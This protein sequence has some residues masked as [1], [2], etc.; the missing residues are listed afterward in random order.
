MKNR[1]E[2]K[3]LPQVA[4]RVTEEEMN[5]LN[6]VKKELVRKSYSD[7]IRVLVKNEYEKILSQN[8]PDGLKR[9]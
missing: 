6:V 4:W 3:I 8:N 5:M 7:T 9:A 1:K 2:N